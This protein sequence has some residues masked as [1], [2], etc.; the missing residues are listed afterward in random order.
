MPIKRRGIRKPSHARAPITPLKMAAVLRRHLEQEADDMPHTLVRNLDY[1]NDLIINLKTQWHHLELSYTHNLTLV[2]PSIYRDLTA[3]LHSFAPHAN[4]IVSSFPKTTEVLSLTEIVKELDALEDEFGG[5]SY[6][7]EE[8]EL[9]VTTDSITLEDINLGSFNIVIELN[10]LGPGHSWPPYR[11]VANEPNPASSDEDVTH[12]HVQSGALCEGDAGGLLRIALT[13]GRLTDFFNMIK[14]VLTTYNAGSPYVALEKWN[15]QQCHDCG[16]TMDDDDGHHCESCDH[17][18][19]SDC[20]HDCRGC[21][22]T[23]CSNCTTDCQ[24][25]NKRFC[26]NCIKT[27]E[28]CNENY[29]ENCLDEGRC[30]ACQ[31]KHEKEQDEQ[32][33][34]KE[35]MVHDTTSVP[36]P[37][38]EYTD[39]GRVVLND[40][41]AKP[42]AP[43]DQGDLGAADPP[44]ISQPTNAAA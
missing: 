15:G 26:G 13:E 44:R 8:E 28:D 30:A 3:T 12:P 10:S 9:S 1:L 37:E 16:Y 19:C 22:N 7:Y 23:I 29:C 17:D 18:F 4:N 36:E 31:E 14:S 25:C 39:I 33:E 34:Q 11:I 24:E 5:W 2:R 35:E 6:N 27:C 41:D 21:G 43:G 20:T 38:P 40:I 32:E 42:V